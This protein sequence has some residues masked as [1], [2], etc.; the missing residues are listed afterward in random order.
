MPAPPAIPRVASTGHRGAAET[1][2][3]RAIAEVPAYR[4]FL[5]TAGLPFT[6]DFAGLPLADKETY[7]Q[8]YPY[9]ELIPFGNWNGIYSVVRSSG[10]SGHPFYWPLLKDTDQHLPAQTE[11]SLVATFAIHKRRTLAIVGLALGSWMGGE[12]QAWILKDVAVR[13]DYPFTVF[14]PGNDHDE[15]LDLIARAGQVP[16]QFLISLCP[17]AIG[18][19]MARAARRGLSLPLRK[20][21]FIVVGEPFP[22]TMREALERRC[23]VALPE[24]IMVSAYGSADTGVVAAE[25]VPLIALRRLLHHVPRLREACGLP[26]PVANLYHVAAGDVFLEVVGGE[27][28]F[29]RWQ[30]IP[31][32][33]YNLHDMGELFRWAGAQAAVAAIA[34]ELSEALRPLAGIVVSSPADLPDVLAVRGRSDG[35]L[36]LAG[37]NL[38]EAML[39]GA[40]EHPDVRRA[41][42]GIFHAR[43]IEAG[44][45]Q[46]LR[47]D[48]ELREGVAATPGLED[49]VY[50]ILVREL[51]RLQ[52]EFADDYANVYRRLEAE[53]ADRIFEI[54]LHPWPALSEGQT[55]PK[56]RPLLR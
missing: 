45:R 27:L 32:V 42:S 36:F 51:G 40:M 25:S 12:Q 30:G 16:D 17:S 55:G 52:P 41:A 35:T 28:V 2:A 31:L 43:V 46:R 50:A 48:I 47:W 39:V 29:T 37:T 49:E 20:L 23:G 5:E 14:A 21:R 1:V 7:C 10:A 4:R 3:R 44:E 38:H 26:D 6:T 22:E 18:H 56:H 9:L 34:P 13:S 24:P 54:H 53:R 19:L 15:I 11:R 8:A 33:R